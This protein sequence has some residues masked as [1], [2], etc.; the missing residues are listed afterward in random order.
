MVAILEPVQLYA[1]RKPSV[2]TNLLPA[3][4]GISRALHNESGKLQVRQRLEPVPLMRGAALVKGKAETKECEH[5]ST[6]GDHR[7][8]P[9]SPREACN[10]DLARA[11]SARLAMEGK[12]TA[13]FL[14][15]VVV[16]SRLVV[17]MRKH[18]DS[19]G[20]PLVQQVGQ[21]S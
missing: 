17:F 16:A 10:G 9:G 12:R 14:Q 20:S 11:E 4:V 7:G 15:Q 8:E 18:M 19:R 21:R 5:V 6:L 3:S 2:S 13:K 1:R